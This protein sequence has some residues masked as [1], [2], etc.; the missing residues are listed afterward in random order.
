MSQKT[1]ETGCWILA[2]L[3]LGVLNEASYWTIEVFPTKELAERA[4]GP[5]GAVVESLGKIWLLTIGEKKMMDSA[6]T[7]VTQ[8]GPIP[9]RAGQSYTAQFMEAT[10]Q[11]GMVS[12]TH[13]HSGTEV[14][15]TESGETCLETPDGKQVGK[16]GMSIMV[17][18]GVPMELTATGTEMRR[19]MMLI[20]HDSSKP[21]T[22]VVD[23]WASKNLCGSA[24]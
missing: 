23:S 12:R 6:G 5:H 19:G 16:K 3:P 8:I 10:L 18:E 4:K 20:L 21:P 15:Y 7:L 13:L 9:V 1:S 22:T 14:F 17:P 11:P 24:K 2:S